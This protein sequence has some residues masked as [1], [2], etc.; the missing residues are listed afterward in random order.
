M[1]KSSFAGRSFVIRGYIV[2]APHFEVSG[3]ILLI[4]ERSRYLNLPGG[5]LGTSCRAC[6]ALNSPF[7]KD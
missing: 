5:D 6:I 2:D 7:P 3:D 1:K 4:K